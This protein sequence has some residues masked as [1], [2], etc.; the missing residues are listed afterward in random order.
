VHEGA[1][2]EPRFAKDFA[3][4]ERDLHARVMAVEREVLSNEFEKADVWAEAV[5]VR[6]TVYRRVVRSSDTY[7]SAAGPIRVERSLYKDRTDESSLSICPMELRLGIVEARWTPLATWVVSQMTP[8]AAE[9]LF[10]R[11]GN[12]TPSKS[13][14]A[15]LHR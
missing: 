12:M 8:A 1:P 7:F 14:I 9:E 3:A 4:F 5:E 2:R 13:A 10:E 6:G 15:R 11:V